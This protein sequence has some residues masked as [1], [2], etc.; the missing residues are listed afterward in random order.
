MKIGDSVECLL[1][2]KKGVVTN[3]MDLSTSSNNIEVVTLHWEDGQKE[4]VNVNQSPQRFRKLSAAEASKEA[5][6]AFGK[7]L[8]EP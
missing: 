2:E 7:D 5:N 4:T 8:S 3:K 1:F 6:D